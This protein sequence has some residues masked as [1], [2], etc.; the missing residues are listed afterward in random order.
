M[1]DP[2]ILSAVAFIN[3][4]IMQ[5]QFNASERAYEN[6]IYGHDELKVEPVWR[7]I[8]SVIVLAVMCVV[9]WVADMFE[10]N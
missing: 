8:L 6:D 2:F 1:P 4:L 3:Y 7:L 5:H 10:P 9:I